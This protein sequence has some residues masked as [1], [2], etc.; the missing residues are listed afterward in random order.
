MSIFKS[1]QGTLNS[2]KGRGLTL[3][4]K[5]QIVKSF[6]IPQ[7]LSKATLI[8]VPEDHVKEINKLIY[9]F[10]WKGNDKIKRSALIN[11]I[12]DGSLKMLDIHSMI[13]AQR[14]M[15]FKKYA[16]EENHSSWK[17]TLD[18]FL[19]GVWGK[20]ILLCNFDTKKLPIYL[21]PFYKEFLDARSR[22]NKENILSYEDVASQVI[23][24]NKHMII[25]KHSV[26]EEH[27]LEED[28]LT[29]GDLFCRGVK[30]DLS[31]TD[32]FK[33][34]S[35]T[36]AV[37]VEWRKRVKQSAH[38]TRPELRNKVH[39]KIDNADVDLSSVT[40]KSLYN[41]FTMA[42]QTPPSAQKRFQDQFPDVQFDW[43]EIYLLSFKV[44]L[45]T[46][47]REFQYKV[48][49]N[50]VFTNE[51]LFKIKMIDSPQFTFRKNE[52]ESL[53]H[54]FCNCEIT[55]S[56]CVALRS[57]LM[58]CNINLEPL[59]FFNALFGIFNAGEDFVTVNHLIL[60]EKCYIYRCKL[61]GVKPAMRVLT[62]KIGAI[63]NI[64]S[65]IAFMRNKVEF[66][67]KKC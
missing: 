18:Y 3:I 38:Y 64:E 44:L 40:S 57:W 56:F 34:M 42:K 47:I 63:L 25:K 13:C 33:L 27:L 16:D 62:T 20:F 39:L 9:H 59:S 24:N 15:V 26:F 28:I 65:R 54:L 53:E 60:V 67:D 4:G 31:P 11:D 29:V 1:I 50:I 55:R 22:L 17:I 36:D 45:E 8:S 66:H 14:V 5:I 21:P 12:N 48:L 51:K 23:W 46:K 49:N 7:F 52:I 30:R 37:P 61:N 43:N 10:I 35:L 32:R 19:S 2:W 6:I 41:A 58:E